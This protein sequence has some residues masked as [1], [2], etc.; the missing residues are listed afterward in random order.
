MSWARPRDEA[1]LAITR[2][3]KVKEEMPAGQAWQEIRGV[4]DQIESLHKEPK[5]SRRAYRLFCNEVVAPLMS[6]DPL[7]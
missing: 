6:A 2:E 1:L 7:G 4:M 5:E 3:Q